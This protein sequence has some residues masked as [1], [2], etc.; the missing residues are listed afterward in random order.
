MPARR[1]AE[2]MAAFALVAIAPPAAAQ[3]SGGPIAPDTVYCGE[4]KLGRYFYCDRPRRARES[5]P[6]VIESVS[7]SPLTAKEE[8]GA[9]QERLVELRAEAVLR[10]TTE[11]VSAYI[12]FQRE[13]LDRASTFSDVWRRA[14]WSDPSLDY[15]LQRPVSGVSK[16]A[17]LDAR[18]GDRNEILASLGDRYGLFYFY[19]ASCSACQEFSPILRGFADAHGISVKA[20]SVDGGPSPHFP[21]AVLD[22]GQ[23]AKLGLGGAPT[24]ALALFDTETREVTPVAFGVVAQSELEE[25]IFVLTRTDPGEDY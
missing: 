18:K 9:I 16:R 4:R 5:A 8:V 22:S 11:S 14:L 3:A 7:S 21:G 12:R 25:R 24:P 19:A 15:T 2:V 20:V 1:T 6:D 13:Q 10:P 23:M 17:W